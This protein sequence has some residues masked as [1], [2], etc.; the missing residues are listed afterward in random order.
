[1]GAEAELHAASTTKAVTAA[2]TLILIDRGQLSLDRPLPSLLAEELLRDI[3]HAH[4]M[5]VR[6]LLLHTS[7]LYSPNNDP[8]YLARY[9]G[10]ERKRLPFWRPEEIVAFAADPSKPPAFAPGEGQR[11]GDINYV[12]LGLIVEAV[13]GRPL[14]RFVR[15][16]IL[17]PLNMTR[18]WYLSE[19][20]ERART[21]GYTFDS[22]VLRQIGLDPDL[23]PDVEGWIDTTDAAE[24][25]DGAAGLI[26]TMPDLVRFARAV[27]LG[28]LLSEGSRELLLEP[29]NR[30]QP[31]GEDEALGVLRAYDMPYGKILTAEGDGPGTNVVW[32]LE[33]DSRVVV[34]AAVN[35]FGRWDENDLLLETLVPEA[36]AV[37]RTQ[38]R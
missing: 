35:A 15:E 6:H 1:M 5:T 20:P 2:A 33:L 12:L 3:P 8:R 13:D 31:P 4:E 34:A 18:T 36:L 25:S 26:T 16:E 29:A 21:R 17:G 28:S 11:Y 32:A 7:G 9:I 22:D 23:E 37:A 10:P 38:G 27:T 19:A 30:A 24:Q 14:R